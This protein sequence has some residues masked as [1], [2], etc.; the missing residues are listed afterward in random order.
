MYRKTISLVLAI[1]SLLAFGSTAY[2]HSTDIAPVSDGSIGPIH[3]SNNYTDLIL[4]GTGMLE[5]DYI[6]V[7]Y[8]NSVPNA[9]YETV[10]I[11]SNITGVG[12]GA[13]SNW[14]ALRRVDMDDTV[15]SIGKSAF[16]NCPSLYRVTVPR[17]VTDIGDHAFNNCTN[18]NFA[19]YGFNDSAA[20]SYA[21][22]NNIRFVELIQECPNCHT[23]LTRD[24]I[25]IDAAI[26]ET[27]TTTG[28]TEGSHCLFCQ[29][30]LVKQ[31]PIP[32]SGHDYQFIDS[33]PAT[34]FHTGLTQ[35]ICCS[36]CNEWMI[37]QAV[38]PLLVGEGIFGDVDGDSKV[39]IIDVT[40]IQRKLANILLPFVFNDP[41]A[42]T[43]DDGVISIIDATYI[44]RW[45]A[46]LPSNN[47]IGITLPIE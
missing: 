8:V 9:Y 25:I 20:E 5:K 38:I 7:A 42:D 31:N 40:Y 23:V 2:A 21:E 43:D 27:C 1:I 34:Y 11:K 36:R 26:P 17:S 24:D 46:D 18:P 30:I 44:Q 32:A 33:S 15:T 19:I 14:S 4:S 10:T 13:F 29:T 35:G 6:P 41:I 47:N 39:S 22:A 3:Y 28:L 12:D 37:K 16:S 45:L